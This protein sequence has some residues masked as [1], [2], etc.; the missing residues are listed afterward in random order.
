MMK[1]LFITFEGIDGC[2]KSTQ[3]WKT[4]KY[5]FDKNKHNHVIA[6]REP[7]SD[8]EIRKILQAESDPYSQAVELTKRYVEDRKLHVKELINPALEKGHHVISDR[9]SLSTFAYQQTQGI[10]LKEL[11]KMHDGLPV[12][13]AVF[14]VDVPVEVAIERMKNDGA[15][16]TEQKFEKDIEFIRKLRENYLKLKDE[17]KDY[18]TKKTGEVFRVLEIHQNSPAQKNCKQFSVLRNESISDIFIIDGTKSISEI[19]DCQIKPII[20]ILW[21]DSQNL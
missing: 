7:Y 8:K 6:T 10:P 9:Y 21:A 2:G 18:N 20:D 15:R 16:Q 11:I 4:A 1:G 19:F 14:I 5:I 12:P 17:L 3:L 13:D